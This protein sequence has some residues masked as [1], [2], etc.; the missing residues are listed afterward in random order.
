MPPFSTVNVTETTSTENKSIS[1]S[2]AKE[3]TYSSYDWNIADAKYCFT[4]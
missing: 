4:F 2:V 1:K 3:L